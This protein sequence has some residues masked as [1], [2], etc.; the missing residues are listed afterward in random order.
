MNLFRYSS[1]AMAATGARGR[2]R[3]RGGGGGGWAAGEGGWSW[4]AGEAGGGDYD[5]LDHP[6]SAV[7]QLGSATEP[8]WS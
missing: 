6:H 1:V 8:H 7:V 4:G 3:R 5:P 2:S